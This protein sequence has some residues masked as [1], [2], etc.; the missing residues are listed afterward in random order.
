MFVKVVL[1]M[2]ASEMILSDSKIWHFAFTICA[3]A[4]RSSL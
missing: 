4:L 2:S 3:A 1:N